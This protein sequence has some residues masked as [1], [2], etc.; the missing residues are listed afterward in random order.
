MQLIAD[1]S[2]KMGCRIQESSGEK[3]RSAAVEG[4]V[5]QNE[6]FVT[7]EMFMEHGATFH[8]ELRS[9]APNGRVRSNVTA[10][11][12]TPCGGQA[13][14]WGAGGANSC[15]LNPHHQGLRKPWPRGR[16]V[17]DPIGLLRGTAGVFGVG[18]CLNTPRIAARLGI[19]LGR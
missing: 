8:V 9:R 11:S 13:S 14:I 17:P 15:V 16:R 7:P 18:L 6:A 3:F 2:P 10:H 5:G 12:L 1:R 19:V 4:A